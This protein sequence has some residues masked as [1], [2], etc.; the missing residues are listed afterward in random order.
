[1]TT[2]RPGSPEENGLDRSRVDHVRQSCRGWVEQDVHKALGVLVA[3]RGVIAL[4][5]AFGRLGP[6]EAPPLQLDS[7]FP[8]ASLSKVVTATALMTLVEDGLVGLTRPVQEYVPEFVGE[9]KD[10]VCVHH[11]LTHT[12]GLRDQD[13]GMRLDASVQERL[14]DGVGVPLSRG[15][16]EEM[17]YC[18]F[19]Y[20]LVGEIVER[21]S[22]RSL[23]EFAACRIFDPLGM[24][25]TSYALADE[26]GARAIGWNL[27]PAAIDP[28]TDPKFRQTPHP[29]GGIWTTAMDTAIFGQAFLNGGAY[30]D[31]RI[32]RPTTVAEM[33]RNQIPGI[34]ATYGYA[35]VAGASWG[36][37]WGIAGTAKWPAYPPFPLGTFAHSG[38][39]SM[40]LWVDPS[41]EV[42]GVYLSI[43]RWKENGTDTIN[44]VDLFANAVAAAVDD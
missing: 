21:V 4:H 23:S 27:M 14:L 1:L 40:M 15:P 17:E 30:G 42:V 2:L 3:R 13:I 22:G 20:V 32:L 44:N 9:G 6:H 10:A 37:G 35:H 5:E 38:S 26:R 24:D 43:C 31:A 28:F 33:T 25:D 29:D 19:N 41:H 7:I 34:G 12:S 11:L 36:Y 39:R 16:G 8:L 18:T